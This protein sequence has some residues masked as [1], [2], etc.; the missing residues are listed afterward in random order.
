MQVER[1]SHRATVAGLLIGIGMGGFVGGIVLW[2]IREASA[3][4]WT[5]SSANGRE[6]STFLN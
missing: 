2:C 1:R 5:I 6:A 4:I 3:R